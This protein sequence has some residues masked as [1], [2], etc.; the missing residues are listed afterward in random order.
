MVGPVRG[1]D[2]AVERSEEAC[3]RAVEGV[4]RAMHEGCG[5]G[6]KRHARARSV[7]A[8]KVRIVNSRWGSLPMATYHVA[9]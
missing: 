5:G 8:L 7:V 6:P 9:H 3:M 4:Q 1:I 2:R